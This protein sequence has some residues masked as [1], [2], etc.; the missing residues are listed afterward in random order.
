MEHVT[1]ILIRF[2]GFMSTQMGVANKAQTE[3]HQRNDFICLA[4]DNHIQF[5]SLRCF[6]SFVLA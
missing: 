4:A 1:F 6:F 5:S 2:H 3:Q